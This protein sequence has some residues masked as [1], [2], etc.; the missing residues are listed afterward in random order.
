[1]HLLFYSKTV[2]DAQGLATVPTVALLIGA[3]YGFA[4]AAIDA[5][6]TLVDLFRGR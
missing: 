2:L 1:M 3:G 5:T 6:R 4:R